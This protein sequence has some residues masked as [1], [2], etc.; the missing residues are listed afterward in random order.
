M[1]QRYRATVVA[2]DEEGTTDLDIY[3]EEIDFEASPLD[4]GKIMAS[5]TCLELGLDLSLFM[6]AFATDPLKMGGLA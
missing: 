5:L 3:C 2:I 1:T 6:H 4:L